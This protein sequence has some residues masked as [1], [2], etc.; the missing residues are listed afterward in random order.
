M[1]TSLFSGGYGNI[2]VFL[3]CTHALMSHDFISQA[4]LFL[5]HKVEK[6]GMAWGKHYTQTLTQAYTLNAH[7]NTDT[8]TSYTSTLTQINTHVPVLSCCLCVAM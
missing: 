6:L 5:L 7:R 8:S 3:K 2:E 1:S 4:L